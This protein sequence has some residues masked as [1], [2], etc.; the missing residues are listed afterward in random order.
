MNKRREREGKIAAYLGE[1]D[2]SGVRIIG[3]QLAEIVNE[4][5]EFGAVLPNKGSEH[6]RLEILLVL[7]T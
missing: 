6:L 4:I 5:T 3:P 1:H 7:D 2:D